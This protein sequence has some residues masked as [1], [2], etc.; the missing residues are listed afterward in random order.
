MFATILPVTNFPVRFHGNDTDAVSPLFSVANRV[1][2]MQIVL[3][4]VIS[5]IVVL[6][7]GFEVRAS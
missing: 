6:L 1:V 3:V 5:I 2:D 7:P 4:V